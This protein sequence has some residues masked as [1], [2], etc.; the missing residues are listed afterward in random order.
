MTDLSLGALWGRAVA[1]DRLLR[2][3]LTAEGVKPE[4]LLVDPVDR[5]RLRRAVRINRA[6]WWVFLWASVIGVLA[7]VFLNARDEPSIPV[8]LGFIVTFSVWTV[9]AIVAPRLSIEPTAPLTREELDAYSGAVAT[10]IRFGLASLMP[11]GIDVGQ[12]R[13]IEVAIDPASAAVHNE[14]WMRVVH[15]R[16]TAH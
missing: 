16:Q 15:A 4:V 7:G 2:I 14:C 5:P 10:D 3:D 12:C 1:G 6:L 8:V 9:F 13:P 11:A